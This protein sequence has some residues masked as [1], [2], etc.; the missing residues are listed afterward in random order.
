MPALKYVPDIIV[1]LHRSKVPPEDVGCHEAHCLALAHPCYTLPCPYC[2]LGSGVAVDMT[3][4][5]S[6]P[7]H[8]RLLCTTCQR[9]FDVDGQGPV[10]PQQ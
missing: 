2:L 9:E 10:G 1:T 6:D 5:R 4:V 8:Q 7:A 3:T